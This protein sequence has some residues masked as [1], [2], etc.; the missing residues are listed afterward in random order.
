MNDAFDLMLGVYRSPVRAALLPGRALPAQLYDVLRLAGGDADAAAAAREATGLDDA[1][2]AEAAALLLH[3]L[4]FFDGAD[5][6]RVLGVDADV[7]A[8]DLKR[9]YRALMRWLHPDRDPD[10]LNSVF[11][12]RVNRAWSALRTP[13]RRAD[14]DS[15][16][17]PPDIPAAA[18]AVTVWQP[19]DQPWL[20][21]RAVRRLP[22]LVAAMGA[23]TA[24]ALLALLF[25]LD[26]GPVA[27]SLRPRAAE[28][29]AAAPSAGAA[30]RVLAA[31]YAAP[32]LT[33]A[34][35]APGVEPDLIPAVVVTKPATDVVPPASA[36]TPALAP[37]AQPAAQA[38][39]S[40]AAAMPSAAPP[41]TPT[42][43]L[44]PQR[45]LA[46][47]R[48][49][50]VSP[51]TVAVSSDPASPDTAVASLSDAEIR[52]FVARFEHLYAGDDV[53]QFLALFDAGVVGNGSDGLDQ[54]RID[55]RRL[56]S[57]HARRE[58]RL[59]DMQWRIDGARA[60]GHGRYAARVDVSGS[61]RDTQGQILLGLAR[62]GDALRIVR[63]NHSGS[64]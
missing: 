37:T 55:Y 16:R 10:N 30:E 46:A 63:L 53:E 56:F 47:V 33:A 2:L 36:T 12:E 34:A 22:Q 25:W 15:Q 64:R 59:E 32:A 58:L 40:T 13:Q 28:P 21:G 54:L 3:Q 49:A 41:T 11:A 35:P 6:Y 7:D 19:L 18:T 52:A 5:H 23:L 4:L 42:P 26:H 45:R 20:S 29:V 8:E 43:T 62:D 48:P 27:A 51:A 44:A 50:P 17:P 38:L 9:H 1:E 61:R 14:Y 57:R 24:A 31:A 60:V 39:A